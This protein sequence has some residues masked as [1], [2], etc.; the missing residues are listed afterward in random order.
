MFLRRK[1]KKGRENQYILKF[2]FR[3]AFLSLKH[4]E[5]A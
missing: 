2:A 3:G 1:N 4:S 5:L